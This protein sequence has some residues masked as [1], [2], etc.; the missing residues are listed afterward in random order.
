MSSWSRASIFPVIIGNLP[1]TS[2]SSRVRYSQPN[3]EKETLKGN[4]LTLK[5]YVI[6]IHVLNKSPEFNPQLD[7]IV[8]IHAN[9]LRKAL[10]QYYLSDG[11]NDPIL[12]SIPKGRYI[13][14][15]ENQPGNNPTASNRK[16]STPETIESKPTV[17]VLPLEYY[18]DRKRL[19]VVCSVLCHD[20]TAELTKFPEIGVITNYS[21]QCAFEKTADIKKL[22]SE[23]GIDYLITGCC[24]MEGERIRISSELNHCKEHKVLWAE[25]YY[26]D[27]LETDWVQG[28]KRIIQKITPA[29]QKR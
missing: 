7:G 5:E 8:R 24:V 18:Q 9:R 15:F 19:D 29:S 10:D 17:A 13:P 1:P 27:D 11:L 21:M 28:Y 2:V 14:I 4:E 22:V 16:S 3:T 20:L 26:I 12:I 23:L 6:A 25:S